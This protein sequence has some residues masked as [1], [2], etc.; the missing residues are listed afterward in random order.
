MRDIQQTAWRPG[1]EKRRWSK[2]DRTEA[3]LCTRVWILAATSLAIAF[4]SIGPASADTYK[5]VAGVDIQ[6][7]VF[8]LTVS[9][10]S[11]AIEGLATI[12]VQFSRAGITNLPLD[13]VGLSQD[14]QT[15]MTVSGVWI[16]DGLAGSK[17]TSARVDPAECGV[18][19]SFEHDA[20]RLSV[21]LLDPT[22]AG[23]RLFVTVKYAG[24]AATGLEIGNTKH[25]DRSFFSENWPNRARHWLPTIDHPY[26][27]ARSQMIVTAPSHYQVV[28]NGLLIEESDLGNGTRLTHWREVGPDR[29]LAQ[30]PRSRAF[31]RAA[32]RRIRGQTCTDLGLPAGPRRRLSRFCGPDTCRAGLLLRAHR[33]LRLREA[34][35]HPEQQRRRR[36]WNRPRQS[37]T[38]MT[39]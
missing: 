15:G 31:R 23:Q 8:R 7:Y 25:G 4:G 36:A 35:Q 12:D 33:P 28:S 2:C 27:K 10:D 3:C 20:N 11:D 21:V 24:T 38:E 19:T 14:R 32:P 9:D 17:V 34:R 6:E 5:R 37:S 29:D 1:R 13:L 30:R 26:D 22:T 39:R 18:P 16:A